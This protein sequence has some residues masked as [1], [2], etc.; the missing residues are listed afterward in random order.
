MKKLV[1]FEEYVNLYQIAVAL[2]SHFNLY[3]IQCIFSR[4]T[5]LPG[6]PTFL[7]I[8]ESIY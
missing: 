2:E 6:L 3:G 8:A 4:K 1:I 7:Y 5:R